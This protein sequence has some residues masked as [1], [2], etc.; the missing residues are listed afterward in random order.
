MQ[1][2]FRVFLIKKQEK[3]FLIKYISYVLILF[4]G[5]V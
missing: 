5:G 4:S 2:L 1:N 3:V